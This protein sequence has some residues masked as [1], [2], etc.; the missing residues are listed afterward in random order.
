MTKTTNQLS[1]SLTCKK[2][3]KLSPENTRAYLNG[4][5]INCTICRTEYR[6]KYLFGGNREAAIQR[7]GE[8]CV[9]CGVTREEHLVKF[10]K[11]ITV[12]HIDGRGSKTPKHLKNNSLDNLQTLCLSCHGVKDFKLFDRK[13]TT[14]QKVNIRHMRDTLSQAKVAEL[15]GV[16]QTYVGYLQREIRENSEEPPERFLLYL[17]AKAMRDDGR[18]TPYIAKK[19]GFRNSSSIVSLL[20]RFSWVSAYTASAVEQAVTHALRSLKSIEYPPSGKEYH[21][22]DGGWTNSLTDAATTL[23]KPEEDK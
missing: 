3:H 22:K 9:R 5:R 16:H 13:L 4:G 23:S 1:E 12:D 2:G 8:K 15:Y 19:L 10:G 14:V 11:D 17:K 18:S 6:N 20:K 7:D 21:F